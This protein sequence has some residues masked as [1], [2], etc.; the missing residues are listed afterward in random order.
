MGSQR[1][2]HDLVTKQQETQLAVISFWFDLLNSSY[3][4]SLLNGASRC[5]RGLIHSLNL[6]ASNPSLHH[7]YNHGAPQSIQKDKTDETQTLKPSDSAVLFPQMLSIKISIGTEIAMRGFA[8]R[9]CSKFL[10]YICY[11]WGPSLMACGILV[12]WAG[13]EPES[14]ALEAQSLNH[15]LTKNI[16]T[17]YNFECKMCGQHQ[18]INWHKFEHTWETVEDREA[19]Q[20]AVHRVANSWSQISNWTTIRHQW[21]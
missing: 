4:S 13:I 20:A 21:Q 14:P 18:Q 11:F 9:Y 6:A 19:R 7:Q 8:M 16:P 2:R 5:P 1:V 12:P 10:K 3:T 17:D 15:W